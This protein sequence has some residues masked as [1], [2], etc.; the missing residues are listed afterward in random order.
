MHCYVNEFKETILPQA[1]YLP[2]TAVCLQEI[3][4]LHHDAIQSQT[5]IFDLLSSCFDH[6]YA[7]L[8][9]EK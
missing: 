7:K 1:K 6:L 9:L 3:C 4:Q 5:P 2:Q 8:K